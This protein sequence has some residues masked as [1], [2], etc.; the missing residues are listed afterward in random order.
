VL[1]GAHPKSRSLSNAWVGP[2][3]RGGGSVERVQG[4]TRRSRG[5]PPKADRW[6]ASTVVQVQ[7]HM[8]WEHRY[9]G[10]YYYRNERQGDRVVKKYYGGGL[11]GALAGRLDA[12]A[13]NK[14]EQPLRAIGEL[15]ARLGP[16]DAALDSLS[17][18][19]NLLLEATLL[20][21]GFYRPNYG[22]WR[23]RRVPNCQSV[24]LDPG[25]LG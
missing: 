9:G 16:P 19:C 12:E 7:R 23:R 3:P 8:G 1:A 20:V 22:A 11:V 14:R 25:G 4:S 5:S 17:N 21:H 18:A 2:A 13:R 15:V 6:T 24:R 10:C